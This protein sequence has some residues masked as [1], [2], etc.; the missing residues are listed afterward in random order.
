MSNSVQQAA[1]VQHAKPIQP[2]ANPKAATI[3]SPSS[4]VSPQVVSPPTYFGLDLQRLVGDHQLLKSTGQ[5]RNFQ[6]KIVAGSATEPTPG[7]GVT[8]QEAI[9]NGMKD[10]TSVM[11]LLT[12]RVNPHNTGVVWTAFEKFSQAVVATVV[13]QPF[14]TLRTEAQVYQ[15]ERFGQLADRLKLKSFGYKNFEVTGSIGFFTRFFMFYAQHAGEAVAEK[16]GVQ[17]KGWQ[18]T[19]AGALVA[20]PFESFMQTGGELALYRTIK[21]KDVTGRQIVRD[22]MGKVKNCELTGFRAVYVRNAGAWILGWAAGPRWV[23]QQMDK[24]REIYDPAKPADPGIAATLGAAGATYAVLT[25]VDV[26]KQTLMSVDQSVRSIS[27]ALLDRHSWAIDHTVLSEGAKA[28]ENAVKKSLETLIAG[29]ENNDPK[30][31]LEAKSDLQV[32]TQNLSS[33]FRNGVLRG[34]KTLEQNYTSVDKVGYQPALR[35]ALQA[36]NRTPSQLL[37]RSV[38]IRGLG[39]G[40]SAMASLLGVKVISSMLWDNHQNGNGKSSDA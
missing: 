4:P 14:S 12:A 5:P 27:K 16:C 15:G 28:Q 22:L 19:V 40:W 31:V 10:G 11:A 9:K 25:P 34:L 13:T 1:S 30:L 37:W 7:K 32:L 35:L 29:I 2:T 8:L 3:G 26:L 18:A 38:G 21:E 23:Q 17:D 39:M 36:T 33:E 24:Q 6:R 20:V